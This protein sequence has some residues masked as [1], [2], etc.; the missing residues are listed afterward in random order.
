MCARTGLPFLGVCVC[1]YCKSL[2][3]TATHTQV[4]DMYAPP[5]AGVVEALVSVS[6]LRSYLLLRESRALWAYDQLALGASRPRARNCMLRD[7]CC[8]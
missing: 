7:A 5:R 3:G 8:M 1:A 4:T 2:A 6:R